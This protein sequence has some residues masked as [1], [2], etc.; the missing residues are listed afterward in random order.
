[1]KHL[2]TIALC[3]FCLAAFAQDTNFPKAFIGT[4][5]GTLNWYKANNPTPQSIGFKVVF[6]P[7]DTTNHYIWQLKYADQPVRDYLLKPVE[8]TKGHW[9]IDERNGILLD[10][11][12]VGNQLTGTFSI[13]GSTILNSYRLEKKQLVVEFHTLAT[14]PIRNSGSGDNLVD[15]YKMLGYQKAILRK[16]K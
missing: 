4:W 15:A 5:E 1:M 6:A 8:P 11:F 7:T 13:A 10:Q 16:I 3:S 2:L 9:V 12:W 14:K